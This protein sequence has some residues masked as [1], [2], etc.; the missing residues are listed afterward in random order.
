MEFEILKRAND[1]FSFN[2]EFAKVYE[3]SHK[4]D[5]V[6]VTPKVLLWYYLTYISTKNKYLYTDTLMHSGQLFMHTY[7]YVEHSS[8]TYRYI[9]DTLLFVATL[10][11][12]YVESSIWG[13]LVMLNG[14]S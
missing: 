10:S 8:C 1:Q 14:E 12:K 5:F 3:F 2:C 4:E 13:S 9:Y 11:T 6:G 7:Q